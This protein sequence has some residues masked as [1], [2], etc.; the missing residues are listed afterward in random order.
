MATKLG[1]YNG[2]LLE[3]GAAQ[4][5]ATSDATKSRYVLDVVYS[6]VVADCLQQASW[7]FA[8]RAVQLDY[9][10]SITPSF[11][12]TY[13][14][15]KPTD[16]MRTTMIS[17][18]EMF[19]LPLNDF[20]EENANFLANVTP[21]YVQYVSNGVDYG[22]DLTLWPRSFARYVEVALAERTC[23]AIT[24]NQGDKDRLTFK[25]LPRAKRD[26]MNKDAMGEGTKWPPQGSWNNARGGVS[27]LNGTRRGL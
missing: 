13:V 19:N 24:Q 22:L 26:A 7:N 1:L 4:L 27:R 20:G 9:D 2:A 18:D 11:G 25:V 5:A 3:L 21:I 10:S 23:A 6:D 12:W 17:G 8:L 16:W 14:F 15:A